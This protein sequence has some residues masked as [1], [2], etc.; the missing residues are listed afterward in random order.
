MEST[1][2][3]VR[4]DGA[5]YFAGQAMRWQPHRD[6]TGASRCRG[7]P[8]I[9]GIFPF[10]DMRLLSIFRRTTEGEVQAGDQ[11]GVAG[12]DQAGGIGIGDAQLAAD[13]AGEGI[14]GDE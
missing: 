14:A 11:A 5:V 6:A 2:L 7:A 12:A 8:V 3:Y 10:Y 13:G 4:A 1:L 9:Y